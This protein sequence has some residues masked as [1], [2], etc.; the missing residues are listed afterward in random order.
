MKTT[1]PRLFAQIAKDHG[2]APAVRAKRDGAWEA[3]SW[4][5]L[6]ELAGLAAR[7][8]LKLGHQPGQAIA[9][10][11]FNRP[12]WVIS[13]LAAI[14]VGGMPAGIYTTST[15]EQCHYI[16]E[17]SEAA[18]AVVENDQQLAK[19]LE[20]RDRLPGLRAIVLMDGGSDVDGVLSW[21]E[22]L[23]VGG[24][25]PESELEARIEAQQ[26]DDLATLIYT[27][28]TTGPPKAVMLSHHNLIWTAK[29]VVDAL[30][31]DSEDQFI[32]YLPLSHIAEQ[33]V[34]F[35]GP[36]QKGACTWFAESLE[37]LPENLR[38]VR[39]HVFFGVPR[40][41]E[42]FQAAI[43]VAGAESKG[44]KK[45]IAAWA[46]RKGLEGGYAGQRGGKLPAF[47]GLSEKLVFSKVR[48]RIGFDRARILA[49]SAAP[50]TLD[51]LEFFL[52]LGMPI[53]EI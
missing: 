32:S 42:K 34:S 48:A 6:H 16:A 2:D 30:F 7:G 19:F 24:T 51:T 45:K 28:G 3:T 49:T 11:G 43:A 15:P 10:L 52:S 46:R 20:I 13:D 21:Q 39:P 33:M 41:W 31:I 38:E 50:I 27:S 37:K 44:L 17:H 36:M 53:L 40:V 22:L 4:S 35:H 12:E 8:F 47:Y 18:V 25:V 26:P 14:A 29:A 23:A 5:R 9:I 1:V